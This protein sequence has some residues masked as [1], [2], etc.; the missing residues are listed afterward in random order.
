MK[1]TLIALALAALPVA[2]MADVTLYGQ[3][4]G[5]LEYTKVK[6]VDNTVTNIN[7]WG[8]RIGFKGEED[9]GNGLKT[10][11]QLEQDVSLDHKGD[12]WTSKRD[13]FIGLATPFG[14]VKA[15]YLSGQLKG[16][17]E[18]VDQWEGNGVRTLGIYTRTSKRYTAVRYDTPE[19][20]GFS[21][22]LLYSPED[23]SRFD[24][25]RDAI[26]G[27]VK[28]LLDE[29]FGGLT[30][31]APAINPPT[32]N[33]SVTE[34]GLNYAN[35]GFFA[36]Y[37]Y[38]LRNVGAN[39]AKEGHV[40]RVE[41]GYDANNLFVAIGYQHTKNV[42]GADEKVNEIAVTGAYTIGNVTPRLSYAHGFS[43]F[44]YDQ[45]IGGVDYALSKR[46]T[47]LLSAGWLK[48]DKEDQAY[49]VGLGLRHKF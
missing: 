47:A 7:D 30:A 39:D 28:D 16:D 12:N 2:A 45:V 1:K 14:T 22:N 37:G 36:K 11:W 41:G 44:K 27:T 49:S 38:S 19:F 42:D 13:S 46:T 21:A 5:G 48:F 29:G 10:I 20:A 17:M 26:P 32:K 23:N 31:A 9:L 8:S 24:Q 43:D 4:K 34:L 40:H 15:G 6:N 25:A 33:R 35:S 3:V 18:T